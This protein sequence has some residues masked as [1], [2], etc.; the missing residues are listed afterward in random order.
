MFLIAHWFENV[1]FRI[2]VIV[3]Y[4]Q[5]QLKKY[6]QMFE[7]RHVQIDDLPRI[8][9]RDCKSEENQVKTVNIS[10]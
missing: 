7:I 1:E 8:L 3:S 4:R 6:K 10:T 2:L 5:A 9:G